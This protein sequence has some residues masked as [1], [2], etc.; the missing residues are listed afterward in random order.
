MIDPLSIASLIKV[1]DALKSLQERFR[2]DD[3]KNVQKVINFCDEV[4]RKL[5]EIVSI[6][7]GDQTGN[8]NRLGSELKVWGTSGIRYVK[9]P[10]TDEEF[11]LL[12]SSIIAVADSIM[13][14][15]A[16]SWT[17]ETRESSIR[18][19]EKVSWQFGGL[20]EVLR[21]NYPPTASPGVGPMT[22]KSLDP[23]A[24]V[25]VVATGLS[26]VPLVGPT[27]A[28]WI[29]GKGDASQGPGSDN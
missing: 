2:D 5:N 19:L 17:P 14:S 13:S 6:L 1:G 3:S 27:L 24:V 10:L 25:G 26:Q 18:E 7:K 23:R 21:F 16:A 12:S 29:R 22:I 4:T 20:V 8:L 28:S 15:N 11:T 9:D